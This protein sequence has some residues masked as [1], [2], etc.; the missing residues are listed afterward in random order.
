MADASLALNHGLIYNGSEAGLRLCYWISYGA[1]P[2]RYHIVACNIGFLLLQFWRR[3]Q[4]AVLA[5]LALVHLLKSCL[6]SAHAGRVQNLMLRELKIC[7]LYK[8]L[9]TFLSYVAVGELDCVG[10]TVVEW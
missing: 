1:V 5:V 9:R 6:E 3:V 2:L 8:G 7:Q 10:I 4:P